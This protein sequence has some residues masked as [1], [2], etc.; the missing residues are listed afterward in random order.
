MKRTGFLTRR[1]TVLFLA[2]FFLLTL[3][4]P[5]TGCT[6]GGDGGSGAQG[7]AP[8]KEGDFLLP[9]APGE[10]MLGNS[11]AAIDASNVNHG[12]LCIQYLGD[13]GKVK[14]QIKADSETYT[15]DLKKSDDYLVFPF[16]CGS[17]TY[18]VEVYENI[19]GNQYAQVCGETIDV[20][21]ADETEPFLYP[22]YYVNYAAADPVVDLTVKETGSCE[23]QLQVVETVFNYVTSTI[24]YDYD[25]ADSVGSGYIPELDVVLDKKTGICFDYASLM[26]AMLRIRNIPTKLVVGYSGDLY[27]AWISVY[28]TDVGWVDNVIEFDGES[29]T[30]MDPTF[31]AA[32]G[33]DKAADYVGNQENYHALYFY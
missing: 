9:S 19:S 24:D 1:R 21:L 23:T 28:I 12:Y 10:V 5:L 30:L 22:N 32:G 18:S 29:W 15:Y 7:S 16:S 27:H 26:S 6:G 2:L 25:L 33:S 13:S 17:N 31:A 4:A 3:P 8:V 11:Y 14:L 20:S